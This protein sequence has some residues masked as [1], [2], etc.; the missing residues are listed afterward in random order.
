MKNIKLYLFLSSNSITLKRDKSILY[1]RIIITILVISIFLLGTYQIGFTNYLHSW[2]G[3]ITNDCPLASHLTPLTPFSEQWCKEKKIEIYKKGFPAVFQDM[4]KMKDHHHFATT[5]S[6]K[7]LSYYSLKKVPGIYMITN[8]IKKKFYIGMTT[9]LKGRFYNYL[10]KNRLIKDRSSRIN[11]ALLKYGYDKFSI[12]I[13]ELPQNMSVKSS[14][15]R[16][17]EDFFIRVFRPQYNIRR[18]S[19]NK[20]LKIGNTNIKTKLEIPTKVKNLLDKC[21]D[22]DA[23][24]WNLIFF[25]FYPIKGFYY[26]IAITPKSTVK[27]NSEGWFQGTVQ[28][29]IGY[30]SHKK[31]NI[32]IKGIRLAYPLI[33][34]EKLAHFYPNEEPKFV[35]ERLSLK[36]KALDLKIQKG[37]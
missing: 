20:D 4:S 7:V 31:K 9:D 26:F 5:N 18:S 25:K 12:S 23:L 8:K 37:N 19:F 33:D 11:K 6:N 1:F 30:D 2:G 10:D 21:L 32:P 13:I 14:Y 35:R 22:P 3:Q 16:E 27:I 29:D 15:L 17:R 24:E 34:K 28:K 36:I